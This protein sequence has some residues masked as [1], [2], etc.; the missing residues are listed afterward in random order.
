MP[1]AVHLLTLS[2]ALGLAALAGTP[3]AAGPGRRSRVAW[4]AERAACGPRRAR[5]GPVVVVRRRWTRP[6]R[7]VYRVTICRTR[8]NV[9][10]R[11][12]I[13]SPTVTVVAPGTLGGER[14]VVT[15][16]VATA[17]LET[18]RSARAGVAVATG[19]TTRPSTIRSTGRTA[20]PRSEQP[21]RDAERGA[22]LHDALVRG[23]LEAA[24]AAAAW[25]GGD[26]RREGALQRAL[27]ATFPSPTLLRD[28]V[29]R[30]A[31]AGWRDRAG[32]DALV[33]LL[34]A[35]E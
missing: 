32:R 1:R 6:A 21:T 24:L 20:R 8:R 27:F 16:P 29:A 13:S 7:R 15:R 10:P 17:A 5:R 11:V 34:A 14:R 35:P 33:R 19:R 2:F 23:D 22:A 18:G 31:G 3:A 30:L 28:T 12:L 9:A 26:P 4:R 25:A